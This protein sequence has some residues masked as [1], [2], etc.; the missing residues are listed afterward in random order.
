M[1]KLVQLYT[2]KGVTAQVFSDPEEAFS[3]LR[4]QRR[5]PRGPVGK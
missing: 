3:W 2:S 5:Q 1:H 4:H